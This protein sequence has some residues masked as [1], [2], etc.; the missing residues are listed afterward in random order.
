MTNAINPTHY[1]KPGQMEVIDQMMTLYGL[2]AVKSFCVCNA[3]K[4]RM[5]AG[6]K[7]GQPI[8]QDIQKARWYEAMALYLDGMGD[9]PREGAY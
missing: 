9:D 1:R 8:E 6:L 3:Y 4:Y 5:R 7:L 2:D